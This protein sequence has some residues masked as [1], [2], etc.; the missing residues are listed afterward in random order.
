VQA[1]KTA[2][3]LST[4]G[5]DVTIA[6]TRED[7]A[8]YDVVHCLATDAAWVREVRMA[9]IPVVISTIYWSRRYVIG[10]DRGLTRPERMLRVARVANSVVRRG[11]EETVMRIS[12][13]I[14]AQQLAFESADVL[15]PNSEAEGQAVRDELGVT[16][17][18]QVVP[19][20]VDPA[21]FTMPEHRGPRSGVLYVGRIEPH[22]NQLGLI[23]A[24]KGTGIDL[25]IVGPSHRDHLDYLE[26]CHNETDE[27]IRVLGECTLAELVEHYQNAAV[28]AI[29]SWFETT[30][31]VSLEA[32]LCGAA[33]V[34]TDRGFAREYFGA[35]AYYC[36]ASRPRSIRAAV[37]SAFAAGGSETLRERI[38][39]RYTWRHAAEATLAGYELAQRLRR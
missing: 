3:A 29:P 16:T 2:E 38:L 35:D 23:K 18:M 33:L 25:T 37:Q 8:G 31:L 32:C 6:S 12:A 9:G 11:A 7:P 13:P 1:H 4:L 26:Q 15:L 34:T 36:D 20:G 5:V 30:G 21:V 28:H 19:N 22:K 27:H 24:L 14:V 39:L 10:L 17:P